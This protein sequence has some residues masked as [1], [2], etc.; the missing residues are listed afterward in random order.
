MKRRPVRTSL[1]VVVGLLFMLLLALNGP[2]E[3]SRRF[4]A[5]QQTLAQAKPASP[6]ATD[7]VAGVEVT[8]QALPPSK[9]CALGPNAY[10]VYV[11]MDITVANGRRTPIIVTRYLHI[12]RIFVGKSSDDVTAH[13]YELET[14]VHTYRS[15][16]EG[17]SFGPQPSDDS[18][19]V[20]KHN[21]TFEFTAV[22]GIP[23]RNNAVDKIPGTA[24]PGSLALSIELQTWP[25]SR[26]AASLQADWAKVGD[27]ISGPVISYP[28][29]IQLPANPPTDK[30]GLLAP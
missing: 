12:E 26:S 9:F 8:A 16:G 4:S 24:F 20:L 15:F 1:V 21:Q 25:F 22:E 13:K 30:C 29:L 11:P 23:V 27:L 3:A 14:P 19:A 17:M 10:M 28:T 6:G 18:F 5:A 2:S 7:P